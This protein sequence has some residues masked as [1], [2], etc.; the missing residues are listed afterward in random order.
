MTEQP[1]LVYFSNIS[2]NTHRFVQKLG[3]RS[4]RIPLRRKDGELL[5][6]EPYVLVVPT[7]GDGIASKLVPKQVGKFLNNPENRKHIRG[8]IVSGNSNF[9]KDFGAAG[10]II[11]EKCRVPLLYRV[12]LMGTPEDVA[13]AKRGLEEFWKH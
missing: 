13:A 10:K 12:E 1:F 4:E 2:E 11:S 6:E 8:V 3:Y 7:Y 5:V 9:G